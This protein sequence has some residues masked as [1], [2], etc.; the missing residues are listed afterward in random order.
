M[1]DLQAP[2][3]PQTQSSADASKHVPA[4]PRVC[5]V[6]MAQPDDE[7]DGE[8]APEVAPP[9][10]SRSTQIIFTLVGLST[11][12]L[13]NSMMLCVDVLVAFYGAS[14]LASAAS[15]QNVL[16]GV[17]MLFFTVAPLGRSIRFRA[18]ICTA[19]VVT[20]AL[21]GVGFAI[22]IHARAL[23]KTYFLA[24]VA[25]NGICTGAAQNMAASLSGDF[26]GA[27]AAFLLGES[28]APLVTVVISLVVMKFDLDAYTAAAVKLL[29]SEV[30][31]IAAVVALCRLRSTKPKRNTIQCDT[32]GRCLTFGGE[33]K[34]Y[35]FRRL[36]DLFGNCIVAFVAC[37]IWVFLLCSST[38]MS[39]GLCGDDSSC[40]A[41]LPTLMISA[42]N[43]AAVGGRMIG[44]K[45]KHASLRCIM[46]E[47]LLLCGL[48]VWLIR[49]S[50]SSQLLEVFAF[51]SPIKIGLVVA[52]ALTLW[53]NYTLMCNDHNAQDGC[54]HSIIAPCPLTTQIMW[55]AIQSGSLTGTLLA[56]RW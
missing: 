34:E 16:C 20:M 6:T 35:A 1:P 19:S 31:M 17:A 49:A 13:W 4:R 7:E 39:S 30:F 44:L 27:P 43:F 14:G 53:S 5:S 21:I 26:P 32:F 41:L 11:S 24:A 45:R 3:V 29:L 37:L 23:E 18:N 28:Y 38:F 50:V 42:A 22:A 54:G 52:F 48:G 2:L 40:T 33:A 12:V 36:A 10:G 55:V 46:L 9:T 15:S 25:V 47:S 8:Q 56:T 51:A